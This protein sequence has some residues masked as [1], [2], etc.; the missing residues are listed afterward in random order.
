MKLYLMEVIVKNT[1]LFLSMVAVLSWGAI[2]FGFAKDM[3]Q[4]LHLNFSQYMIGQI[5]EYPTVCSDNAKADE[6]VE[7]ICTYHD[8]TAGGH[9]EFINEWTVLINSDVVHDN[10]TVYEASTWKYVLFEGTNE[11]NFYAKLYG[12][13]DGAMLLTYIPNDPERGIMI[14]YAPSLD[15]NFASGDVYENELINSYR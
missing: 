3:E 4:S 8:G 14:G 1:T 11:V 5:N 15:I 13:E 7:W 2:S 10:Y 6:Y 12:F 9:L